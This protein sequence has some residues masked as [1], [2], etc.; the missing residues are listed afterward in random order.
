MISG[1]RIIVVGGNA[2]G[3]AAAAKA[4][5]VNPNARVTLFEASSF[6]STGTCEIPY[7]LSGKIKSYEDIVYYSAGT[8]LNKKGVGVFINHLVESIDRRGKNITVKDLQNDK[9]IIKP[10]DSLILTTGSLARRIPG[11]YKELRNVFQLKT[12][13]DLI[14]V[15]K[16]IDLNS[17]HSVTIIGSGY[18]GIEASEALINNNLKVIL[19]EKEK[20][21]L[22]IAETEISK[23]VL[24]ELE[25]NSVQ[26]IGGFK[27]IEPFIKEDVVI[28]IKYDDEHIQTDLVLLTVGISPNSTLAEKAKLDLG[29]FGGIKVDRK[30]RTS[31]RNIFAAGDNIEILNAITGKQ[32]YLPFATYAH[33]Y[34]H[35]AGENAAGGSV[36]AEPI[37]K[38]VSVKIFDNYFASVGL[39]SIEAENSRF[40]TDTASAEIPNLVKVMPGSRNV[41]GKIIYDLESNRILGGSFFGGKEV[42]GYADLIASVIYSKQKID[43]LEKVNYNYTPPLSPFIN[44][45]SVLG[46]KANRKTKKV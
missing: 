10:Y 20:L 2:A 29:K 30:L 34:G 11:F 39:S 18:I 6:I 24:N 45:L 1:K 27:N 26:F 42:S 35:I 28:S 12:I 16:Y 13:D 22:P 15:K 38:N 9:T 41:F 44:L 17:V 5:R 7:V 8:F 25:N 21:P 3:P 40:K 14:E 19:F 33:A 23:K 4:K 31:D 43:F 32:D 46:G 37:I 36:N